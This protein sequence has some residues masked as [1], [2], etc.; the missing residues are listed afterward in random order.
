MIY[1][2]IYSS[3]FKIY[4]KKTRDA[5]QIMYLS[6][7]IYNDLV[8]KYYI[9]HYEQVKR[10]GIKDTHKT[11]CIEY[12]DFDGTDYT[13]NEVL[14]L[15][16]DRKIIDVYLCHILK[17]ILDMYPGTTPMICTQNRNIILCNRPIQDVIYVNILNYADILDI[18]IANNKSSCT[19]L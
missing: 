16:M 10:V 12:G 18:I 11:Y 7:N 2:N 3:K 8:H 17:T 4:P 6:N 15:L 13:A 5:K 1:L 19:I 9:D 14:N